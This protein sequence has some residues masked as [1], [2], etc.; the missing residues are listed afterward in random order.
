M[1]AEEARHE[2][3]VEIAAAAHQHRVAINLASAIESLYSAGGRSLRGVAEMISADAAAEAA[4]KALED[5]RSPE[6]RLARSGV[7]RGSPWR[8]RL[9]H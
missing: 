6:A 5:W 4:D 2:R 9:P 3:L 8:G 1:N 7:S